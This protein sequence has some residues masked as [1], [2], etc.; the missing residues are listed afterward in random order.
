MR[1]RAVSSPGVADRAAHLQVP[2]VVAQ[3][4]PGDLRAQ[5]LGHRVRDGD[6]H[7]VGLQRG[8]H[9]GGGPAQERVRQA[10][11]PRPVD[12]RTEGAQRLQV[13]LG[14]PDRRRPGDDDVRSRI[15]RHRGDR[16]PG[17]PARTL[18]RPAPEHAVE[19]AVGGEHDRLPVLPADD[20][21]GVGAQQRSRRPDAGLG[22]RLHPLGRGR[23]D[24]DDH[25]RPPQPPA[26]DAGAVGHHQAGRAAGRV[27]RRARFAH[28]AP[29]RG[30]HIHCDSHHTGKS[31]G[32]TAPVRTNPRTS[33]VRMA[34]FHLAA[35]GRP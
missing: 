29:P 17:R 22:D 34:Q 21:G 31:R 30:R 10:S 6:Q 9:A 23:G 14:E 24:V 27:A 3:Q 20:R 2:G 4:H 25:P 12:Q 19:V 5:Q 11:A 13:A 1:S 35:G 15:D 28:A 8:D 16:S 26:L 33:P 7:L 32:G 18:G